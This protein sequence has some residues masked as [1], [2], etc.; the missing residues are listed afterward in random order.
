VPGMRERA[1]VVGGQLT[2]GPNG[3]GWQVRAVLPGASDRAMRS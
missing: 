2:A 1:E 3:R